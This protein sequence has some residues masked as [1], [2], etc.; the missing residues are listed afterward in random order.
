MKQDIHWF[1]GHMAKTIKELKSKLSSIDI[2]IECLDARIPLA[3]RNPLIDT[4]VSQKQTHIIALTKIDLADP[5]IT[6]E[7]V[8]YFKGKSKYCVLLNIPKHLGIKNLLGLCNQIAESKKETKRFYVS[9]VLVCGIPNVGKSALINRIANKSVA[10]VQNKPGV[11][12]HTK[13]NLINQHLE[14]IDTPGILWPKLDQTG[15]AVKLALCLAIKQSIVNDKDLSDFLLDYLE[16]EYPE[17]LKKRY[18]LSHLESDIASITNS[19]TKQLHFLQKGAE[20]DLTRCY[21]KII[22]DFSSNKFV[23]VSLERP[24]LE[25]PEQNLAL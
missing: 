22:D 2:I 25:R 5:A 12:K 11:T 23:S 9:K 13:G 17:K 21:R 7:W 20:L 24:S 15:T 3:S 8:N 6:K 10:K 18:N 19:I 4:F 14:I 1:P 16:K